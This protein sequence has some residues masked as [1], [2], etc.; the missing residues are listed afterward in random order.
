[1]KAVHFGAG[2]I[3]R[4]FIGPMLLDAGY[5]VI[6]VDTNEN[7]VRLLDTERQ[8]PVIIFQPHGIEETKIVKGFGVLAFSDFANVIEAIINADIITTSVG[9]K[10]LENVGEM[11]AKGFEFRHLHNKVSEPVTMI[12]CENIRDNTTLLEAYIRTNL[13][14]ETDGMLDRYAMFP[15]CVVDRIVPSERPIHKNPLVIFVESY[16]RIVLE[17][18]ALRRGHLTVP[19]F[20]Y[21]LDIDASFEQKFFT[22]NTAHAFFAY[23]GHLVGYSHVLRAVEDARIQ[24]IVGGA[25]EEIRKLL[26]AKHSFSFEDH[27]NYIHQMYARMESPWISDEIK[28]V[29]RNPIQK[30]GDRL[31]SPAKQAL[32]YGITPVFLS[33]G[34]AAAM[35]YYARDDAE[36]VHLNRSLKT[37]FHNE[38]TLDFILKNVFE[39]DPANQLSSLI[40]SSYYSTQFFNKHSR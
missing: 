8:Y 24:R 35:R 3:G 21:S 5:E 25:M 15:R 40:K 28:R 32:D 2:N 1:M 31:I 37:N 16:S 6:F 39:L 20:E 18:K 17:E 13:S 7:L 34:I 22:F 33:I 12:A 10:A 19:Q 9:K 23:L 29:A 4:G 11:L 30:L 26:Q 38:E 36:A 27:T 14:K